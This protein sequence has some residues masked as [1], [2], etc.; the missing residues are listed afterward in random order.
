LVIRTDTTDW[1]EAMLQAL[2]PEARNATLS[3]VASGSCAG[4]WPPSEMKG[5]LFH[6][7]RLQ[8]A[9]LAFPFLEGRSHRR[10]V[11]ADR[12]GAVALPG[13]RC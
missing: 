7:L 12:S 6:P 4:H 3:R 9:R 1:T 11:I 13:T 10:L 8:V 2:R 5:G